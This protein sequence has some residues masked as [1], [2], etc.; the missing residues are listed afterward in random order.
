MCKAIGIETVISDLKLEGGNL[1]SWKNRAVI[2]EKVFKENLDLKP[3]YIK[4]QIMDILEISQLIVIP[5]D[6]YDFTGHADGMVRFLNERRIL[7]NDYTSYGQKYKEGFEGPLRE[8]GLEIEYF[9]Y[10][11][12]TRKNRYG[13]F[14][15]YGCYINFLRIGDHFIIPTFSMRNEKKTKRRIEDILDGFTINY[16][17][18]CVIA[19]YGG[20]LN[21]IGWNIYRNQN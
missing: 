13:D 11:P 9:P 8:G 5:C 1:I 19:E 7:V 20:A 15:A 18:C 4:E 12:S 2:T 14:T 3:A 6:P 16:I 21:C 17:D 10:S